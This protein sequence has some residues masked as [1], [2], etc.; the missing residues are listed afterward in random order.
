MKTSEKHLSEKL[1]AK[2][3]KITRDDIVVLLGDHLRTIEQLQ[4]VRDSGRLSKSEAR[5]ENR[6]LLSAPNDR[7]KS[8]TMNPKRKKVPNS[9]PNKANR[10]IK[11]GCREGRKKKSRSKN[12]ITNEDNPGVVDSS[13]GIYDESSHDSDS[14]L[15]NEK[16]PQGRP[17]IPKCS[18]SSEGSTNN[19]DIQM[20]QVSIHLATC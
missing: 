3:S 10:P 9:A 15:E 20:M 8:A 11:P 6:R 18:L 16:D 2:G 19:R 7:K 17:P 12:R 1:L 14:T 5:E 4:H 13:E